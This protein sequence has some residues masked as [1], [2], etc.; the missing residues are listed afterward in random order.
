MFPIVS[1]R[2]CSVIPIDYFAAFIAGNEDLDIPVGF[3]DG[4]DD[5]K[6]VGLFN[7]NSLN[8]ITE[9]FVIPRS[10]MYIPQC[11]KTTNWIEEK[12]KSKTFRKVWGVIQC[13]LKILGFLYP[14]FDLDNNLYKPFHKENNKYVCTN[15]YCNH[16]QTILR[17]LSKSTEK[18]ISD[19]SSNM[20]V[21]WINKHTKTL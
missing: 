21:C 6:L 8:S 2:H 3:Y 4:S 20:K 1:Y 13:G 16:S 18:Q 15:K 19:T 5:Y 12:Y 7:L 10:Y 17:P 9:T 11:Q 14:T